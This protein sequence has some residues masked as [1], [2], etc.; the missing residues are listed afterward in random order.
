VVLREAVRGWLFDENVMFVDYGYR[1]K[2]KRRRFDQPPCIRVHVFQKFPRGP[3]LEAATAAGV[4]GGEIPDSFNDIP[5]DRPQTAYRVHQAPPSSGVN[6]F[7]RVNP[8]R[9]GASISDVYRPIAGT[10]GAPVR[11][12]QTGARMILSNWH[13]FG[14]VYGQ[15]GWPICQPGRADGGTSADNVATLTRH[16]MTSNVD[17][18]VA[19]LNGTR[20]ASSAPLELPAVRG[21]SLAQLGMTV[22]KSGRTSRVTRGIVTGVEGTQRLYYPGFGYRVVRHIISITP[23]DADLSGRGDSGALWI[24][25][26]SMNAVGLHF[27]GNA[28]GQPEEALA[29]DID[30][31]LD[32]LEVDLDV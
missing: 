3:A 19:E 28:P 26:A 30:R 8:L 20:Y 15:V 22:V 2:D 18:A 27:A 4:T 10:L 16:G 13:V 25:E 24:E 1:E 29:I 5:V 21:T 31:V 12:R 11:D 9:G 6:R 32:A 7:G 17:A 23:G 14:G